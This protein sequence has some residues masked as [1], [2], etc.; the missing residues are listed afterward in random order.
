MSDVSPPGASAPEPTTVSEPPAPK[1][2]KR[3]ALAAGGVVL[4]AAVAG[5]GAFAYKAFYGK[6]EQA[7]GVL[8]AAGIL[9]YI[10]LDMSPNG[11]QLLAAR[12]TLKK[13][14]AL[15][16]QI[17]LDTKKDLRRELFDKLHDSGEC[18]DLD[19]DK[20]VAPWLGDGIA[21]AIMDGG[22]GKDPN[23]VLVL[24][25]TDT[26]AATKAAPAVM[27][28][29]NTDSSDDSKLTNHALAGDWILFGEAD[30]PTDKIVKAADKGTLADDEGFKRWTDA[31][32]DPGIMTGYAAPLAATRIVE[33]MEAGG[34]EIPSAIKDKL[35]KFSGL[36]AVVR[37]ADGGVELE[38]ASDSAATGNKGIVSEHG[39]EAAG[40]LPSSTAAAFGFGLA[41]GWV[42][43][44]LDLYGPILEKD[45]GMSAD[46]LVKM[47]EDETGLSVPGD[48]ETLTG[49]SLALAIDGD[50]DGE[51]V[52]QFDPTAMPIGLKIKGDTKAIEKV[53]DKLRDAGAKQG[54]PRNFVVSKTSGDYVV[55][56]LNS[57]YAD[58]LADQKGLGDSDL[59][60]KVVPKD[61]DAASVFFINFDAGNHWLDKLLKDFGAPD[62][63]TDNV[64]P[65]QGVGVSSWVDGD[66]G[67]SLLT[68]TTE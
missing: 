66:E 61:S 28:C 26:A 50:I 33:S 44:A 46:D 10:S 1:G 14:P 47:I 7:A 60:G 12:T 49:E 45:A 16:D 54:M 25:T 51:A 17:N 23:P 15:A 39:A 55:V 19:Y 68:V 53:L 62:D 31:A 56:S 41:K 29:L 38:G 36:G 20:Q 27:K 11:E 4:V 40:S 67:H 13:F 32:G 24:Q 35:D 18:T 42:D 21:I 59:F 43:E 52:Q 9:G 30:A 64:K 57:K 5:G 34:D 65:L 48:I 22:K 37:F 3:I 8:P 63:V 58:K 2:R 6:G